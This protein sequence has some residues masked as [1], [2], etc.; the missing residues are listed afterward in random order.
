MNMNTKLRLLAG[1]SGVVVAGLWAQA[2]LAQEAGTVTE[3]VVTG[4][5]LSGVKAV[6]SPAPIQLIGSQQ[7]TKTGSV[8]LANSLAVAVPSFNVNGN[9]G[10]AAAVHVL[11]ALRGLSPNDT[12]ILVD[13]KRRHSTSNLAVDSGS[14]YS[15][16]ATTD[17]NYLPMDAIDH[18]EVLTD[19]AAAQYG[20]DAIAG[21]INIILKKKSSGGTLTALAGQNFDGVLGAQGQTATFSYNQ[22]FNIGSKGFANITLEARTH[23]FTTLGK[24][25]IR[26]QSASGAALPGLAFPNSNV[27][28]ADNFPYE[29]RVNGDPESAIY[30]LFYNSGY[31]ISS[32]LTAYSFGN[33]SY[34]TSQHFENYRSPSRVS[35]VTTTGVTVY[36][37]PNGFD[38]KE[39]FNET[40]YSF[41]GGLKGDTGGWAWDA[42]L[43]YGGN[44]TMVYV[45]NTANASLFPVLQ[46]ASATP[47]SNPTH[48]IYDGAF[49]ATQLDG[50]L[51]VVRSFNLGFETPVTLAGVSRGGATPT[52]S[53][54]VNRNL[55]T[56]LARS[57]SRATP[58]RTPATMPA[59]TTPATPMSP[60]AQSRS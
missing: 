29:N 53:A 52:A 22:G 45:L 6:D 13:G 46:A 3:I 2:A 55:T 60:S 43:T 25:D 23:N 21:V 54:R 28:K 8:D 16:A 51:D 31:E 59:P 30:N 50:K 47:V 57:L 58:P 19:G 48:T 32:G 10:D 49:D 36:P 27:T 37:I 15:G 39:Q 4:T 42:S 35:G 40:D 1:I 12:L 56:A 20:T 26:F 9:G 14:V 5:R 41:T 11:A 33:L 38:P 18:I 34:N 24:G 7:L 44:H 17:L